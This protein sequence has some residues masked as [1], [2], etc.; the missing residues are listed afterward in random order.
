MQDILTVASVGLDRDWEV[1]GV[2]NLNHYRAFAKW[3]LTGW[4]DGS[5]KEKKRKKQN[6]TGA[7]PK[8]LS[9]DPTGIKVRF[10]PR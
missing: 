7:P 8:F 1:D 9:G 3:I 4:S 2:Y 6:K 5:K 10:G